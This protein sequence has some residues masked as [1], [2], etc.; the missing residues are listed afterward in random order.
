MSHL[1]VCQ[2]ILELTA[3]EQQLCST[4]QMHYHWELAAA[5]K[6]NSVYRAKKQCN[7]GKSQLE[8]QQGGLHSFF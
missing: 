8:Q 1:F 6:G 7:F 2:T 4:T 3:F 5:K